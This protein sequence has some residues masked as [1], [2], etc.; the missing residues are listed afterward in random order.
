MSIEV[1]ANAQ[2]SACPAR[3]VPA[4]HL[5]G[6]ASP[7]ARWAKAAMEASLQI[8]GL[9]L[10]PKEAHN[11]EHFQLARAQ[12]EVTGQLR[13]AEEKQGKGMG[14]DS[15]CCAIPLLKVHIDLEMGMPGWV[16]P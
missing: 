16:H 15:S 4:A 3:L 10:D 5:I 1:I 13:W 2:V 9:R 8:L 11:V 14:F 6:I 7:A 12:H